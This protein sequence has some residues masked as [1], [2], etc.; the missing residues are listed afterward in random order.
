MLRLARVV[1]VEGSE[2]G[3]CVVVN[4]MRPVHVAVVEG[5]EAGSCCGGE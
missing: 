4:R 5:G 1:M 2:A 3:S